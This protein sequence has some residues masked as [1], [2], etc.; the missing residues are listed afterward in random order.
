METVQIPGTAEQSEAN[1][2][3]SRVF[4]VAAILARGRDVPEPTDVV[5]A[6]YTKKH[7]S[8]DLQYRN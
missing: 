3:I 2:M 7:D 6:N 4:A 5:L 8:I 1:K